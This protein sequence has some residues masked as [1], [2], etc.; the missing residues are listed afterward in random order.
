MSGSFPIEEQPRLRPIEVFPID[1]RGQRCLV[2]RDPGDSDLQPIALSDGAGQVLMLLDGQRTVEAIAAAL[3]LR[4]VPANAEQVRA[5]VERLDEGGF[6]EGPRAEHR[7]EQRRAAFRARPL[8]VAVHA[9]GAYPDGL[10]TLPRMLADAYVHPDG[11]GSLPGAARSDHRPTSTTGRDR[12]ARGSAS[13][14][15]YLQLGVQS[16]RRSGAGGAVPRA[17]HL[18][19]AHGRRVCRDQQ[20]VRHASRACTNR[21]RVRRPVAA[22]LGQRPVRGRVLA[23]ERALDRVPGGL[24]ALAG[25]P[26][27]HGAHPVRLAAQPGALGSHVAT[28]GGA[29]CRVSRSAGRNDA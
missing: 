29:G 23:C 19:H 14:C 4:G 12:A 24:P 25:D 20:G 22:S 15:A 10:D 11:P 1:D 26:G 5:F 9:G 6:L 17:R 27:A 18:P 21:R 8:R 2:L 3:Q 16:R 28:R 13:R 7:L